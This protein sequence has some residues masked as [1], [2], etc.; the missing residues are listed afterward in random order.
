MD[1]LSEI[2]A[3]LETRFQQLGY[4]PTETVREFQR[5]LQREVDMHHEGR[6]TDQLRR[7]F[8]DQTDIHFPVVHWHASTRRVLTLQRI[9][10]TLLSRMDYSSLTPERRRRIV[11]SG[12]RAVFRQCLEFGLFHADPHPG[13][14]FI[15]PDDTLC[16]IDCGM[17][18]RIDRQT[19]QDLALLVL[20]V[21]NGDLEGVLDAVSALCSPDPLI[22][23]DRSFRR[24]A[25][26]FTARFER[27][28]IQSLDMAELLNEFFSLLRR[29][30]LRLPR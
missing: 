1:I 28:T 26:D 30:R 8:S 5:E 3:L 7:L 9:H 17:T 19:Q 23:M 14:I 12:A 15:R 27:S 18:G 16:F 24:D 20:A 25:A 6:S 11:A 2:A 21:I 22:R 10:G 29:Y 13:N 4:S